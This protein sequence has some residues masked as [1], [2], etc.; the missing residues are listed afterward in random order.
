MAR[1]LPAS[2]RTDRDVADYDHGL[3][4][5]PARSLPRACYWIRGADCA[6]L[7]WNEGCIGYV[8]PQRGRLTSVIQWR[9]RVLAAP[10]GSVDQGMRWIERWVEKRKGFPG[11]GTPRWYER[12]PR[13]EFS[14]EFYERL[15]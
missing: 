4:M 11:G 5:P 6:H 15:K 14:A 9:D 1:T 12:L 2:G 10:C 3:R 8:A 7:Y 13:S